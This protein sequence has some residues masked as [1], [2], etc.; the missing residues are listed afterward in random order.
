M[1]DTRSPLPIGTHL[2]IQAKDSTMNFVI[3]EVIGCGGSCIV[4]RAQNISGIC[5]NEGIRRQ[6]IKEFYPT[7]ID[8]IIRKGNCLEVPE[9]TRSLF[10]DL[11]KKFCEGISKYVKYYEIDDNHANARP[12]WYGKANGTSYAV[13]DPNDG[14]TLVDFDKKNLA[15]SAITQIMYSICTAIQKFHDNN[16]LYLDCKP[17]NIY[18]RSVDN[19]YHVQLFDFDTVIAIS[20]IKEKKCSYPSYS[21]GWAPIEQRDWLINEIGRETD[22]YSIGA[23]F[24]YLLTGRKPS[25][26]DIKKIDKNQFP[27]R[28]WSSALE[29]ASDSV[30]QISQ[31]ILKNT[32]QTSSSARY[33]DISI[34]KENFQQLISLTLGNSAENQ[35]IYAELGKIHNRVSDTNSRLSSI[36]ENIDAL[37]DRLPEGTDAPKQS[38]PSQV[39]GRR[40]PNILAITAF[41]IA[42]AAAF[43]LIISQRS[44]SGITS[45]GISDEVLNEHLLLQLSNASHQ[46]EMGLQNWRRLDYP[47]ADRDIREARDEISTQKSQSELDVASIN[48]SLGCLYLDMGKYQEAYDYLNAAYVTFQAE[49]GDSSVEA[50]AVRLSIAKYDYYTGNFERALAETQNILD[51]SNTDTE[52]VIV[53]GTSHLRAM[54]FDAQGNYEAAL[55]LYENVLDMYG[56]ISENGMLAKHLANYAND[57]KLSQDEKDYYT[58]AIRWIILTYNHIS[59]VNLHKGDYQAAYEA[60][61]TG[62]DLSLNNI[63]IG[64]RNLTTSKLYMST[65]SAEAKLGLL[66]NGL[67]DIDL[68]MRIQQNL[69]DFQAVY[70]GLVEVYDIYGNISEEKGMLEHSLQYNNSAITIDLNTLGD[71]HPD[72]AAAYAA[73]GNYYLRQNEFELSIESLEFAIEIRKNILAENHP[74]TAA[75]YYSLAIA[76][77]N[78]DK[79]DTAYSNLLNASNICDKCEV[80]Q[81]LGKDISDALATFK[82]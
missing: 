38:E 57:P 65:A 56:D 18:L 4:Y 74:D 37:K 11:E 59:Q 80:S 51:S 76:Q 73:L 44:S 17:E 54:V 8:S 69:F 42:I 43:I 3:E 60:A 50:R 13:S 20:D 41:L 30:L 64:R 72:T 67:D 70:P 79:P 66:D 6:I 23:V 45:Y 14:A 10:E 15:L 29:H 61:Q 32:L 81:Q 52:K 21:K 48:N 35:P 12:F 28:I 26:R 77:Q 71:N 27:L 36:E 63:Y 62:L 58:N 82:D 68:A 75:M 2:C 25:D 78:T 39:K 55:A 1:L 22:I 46:Y 5:D 24:F 16:L 7:A 40:H 47:R 53:A 9:C 49:L 19:Q 33:R 31:R 34:L